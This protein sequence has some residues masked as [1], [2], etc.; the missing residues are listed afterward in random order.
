MDISRRRLILTGIS[1]VFAGVSLSGVGWAARGHRRYGFYSVFVDESNRFFVISTNPGDQTGRARI[2]T[3]SYKPHAMFATDEHVI[4]V[5]KNGPNATL[6]RKS[7]GLAELHFSP[8]DTSLWFYGHGLMDRFDSR[9][10]YVTAYRYVAGY[11]EMAARSGLLLEYRLDTDESGGVAVNLVQSHETDGYVP[12][13]LQYSLDGR[14]LHY[15]IK[16]DSQ[17]LSRLVTVDAKTLRIEADAVIGEA[18]RNTSISRRITHLNVTKDGIVYVF[19]EV[20]AED[21][22]LGGGIGALES[23]DLSKVRYEW[24]YT[25]ALGRR[26]FFNSID[27]LDLAVQDGRPM[28]TLP[29]HN[30]I[31]RLDPTS[32]KFEIIEIEGMGGLAVASPFF[33]LTGTDVFISS[34]FGIAQGDIAGEQKLVVDIGPNFSRSDSHLLVL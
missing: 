11:S 23:R 14:Q 8:P 28:I 21:V 13:H 33:G 17:G 9:K 3:L 7:D 22:L 31:C 32:G 4:C 26:R 10:F 34:R 27:H 16:N 6:L 24:S 18:V 19:N 5:E 15:T 29:A 30:L 12:H 2:E 25:L 1:G 20:G